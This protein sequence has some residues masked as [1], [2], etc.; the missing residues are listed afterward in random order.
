MHVALWLYLAVP[1]CTRLYLAA[2]GS[3][4]VC[5]DLLLTIDCTYSAVLIT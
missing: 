1:G 4:R 5:Y 3:A 2:P